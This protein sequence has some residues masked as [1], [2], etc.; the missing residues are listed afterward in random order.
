MST[1][2]ATT[3]KFTTADI[4]LAA[5][6]YPILIDQAKRREKITYGELI[7][8]AKSRHPDD[9][10]VQAAVAVTVGRKLDAIGACAS[11]KGLPDVTSLVVNATSGECTR[12]FPD[13]D[14][15][16]AARRQVYAFDWSAVADEFDAALAATLAAPAS[17]KTSKKPA[18]PKLIAEFEAAQQLY[19]Y[20]KH[21]E[22]KL[23]LNPLV[24]ERKDDIVALIR[25]GS[26]PEAALQQVLPS[27]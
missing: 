22:P 8:Q 27:N 16:E 13:H 26:S 1:A 18:A 5:A 15:P 14:S 17:A 3:R 2:T 19:L 25:R 23:M 9:P 7:K 4:A 24:Q 10:E 6:F 21:T 11:A 12:N 20:C